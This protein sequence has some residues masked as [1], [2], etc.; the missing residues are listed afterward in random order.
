ME[1]HEDQSPGGLRQPQN[2]SRPIEITSLEHLK[3]VLRENG[4]PLEEWGTGKAK[5]V[6]AFYA[7]LQEGEVVLLH[8]GE[9]LIREIRVAAINIYRDGKN[10]D[11]GKPERFKLLERCQT[12]VPEGVEINTQA[13][14]EKHALPGRRVERNLD[15][16]CSEIMRPGETP[17]DAMIRGC[18][19]ELHI[20]FAPSEI[21]L[22]DKPF[23]EKVSPSFPGLTSRYE[24]FYF[25]TELTDG[26]PRM[27]LEYFDREAMGDG[28]ELVGHMVWKRVFP[29]KTEE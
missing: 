23:K 29:E 27:R 2:T 22:F 18:E 16:S 24:R 20:T 5:P 26:D 3:E 9:K 14:L 13:D 21:D 8:D 12:Y 10:P 17:A 6:E 28:T 7:S 15:T 25:Q 4:I 11:T 1:I 19:E